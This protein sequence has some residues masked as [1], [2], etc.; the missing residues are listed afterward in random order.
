[1][2]RPFAASASAYALPMPS[3]APVTT[4]H[5][6]CVATLST[7]NKSTVNLAENIH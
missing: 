7:E 5:L 6:P 3:V 4:A 1:M 2:S